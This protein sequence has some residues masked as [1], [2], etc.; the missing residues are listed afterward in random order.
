MFGYVQI[1]KPELKVKDFVL[2][3]SFYCGLCRVL[4]ERY[5]LKGQISLSYDMTFL[6][7]L[8]S[9]YYDMPVESRR[10]R[11]VV[12]PAAKHAERIT[13][14]T[15]YGADMNLL[16]TAYHLLDDVRDEGSL[17]AAAGLSLYRKNFREVR[18]NYPEQSRGIAR[19]LGHLRV[20]EKS[21]KRPCL[22]EAADCFGRLMVRLFR[23]RENDPLQ[24]ELD[25]M[26]FHLG[27]FIY[28]S[29][30][31]EDREEDIKKGRFNPLDGEEDVEALLLDEIA[32][33]CHYFEKLP[34]LQY[35]DILRNILYAGVWNRFD[36][37]NADS[38]EAKD[39]GES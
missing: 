7:M 13:D 23:Y 12:H 30:A 33:C 18:E 31:A 3:K 21:G 28:I 36:R 24:H 35:A 9:S 2:Y 22:E 39:S 37:K 26:A 1:R 20:I 17:P 15:R 16:L 8:L 19:E 6:V 14:A 5:G 27:R 32:K 11:C 10:A 34:C 38:A 29:D 25:G 4:R